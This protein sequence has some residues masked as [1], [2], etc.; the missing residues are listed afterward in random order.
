[1]YNIISHIECSD[2]DT[3]VNDMYRLREQQQKEPSFGACVPQIR[4]WYCRNAPENIHVIRETA[5][6]ISLGLSVFL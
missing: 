1:M 6:E 4:A 3:R 5:R 2:A